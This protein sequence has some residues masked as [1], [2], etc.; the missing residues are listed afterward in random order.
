[1]AQV[2]A[3][4]G[5]A[6]AAAAPSRRKAR[7]RCAPLTVDGPRF[8]TG[9]R[10]R[11]RGAAPSPDL[12]VGPSSGRSVSARSQRS[13][14]EP[15]YR[16]PLDA[17]SGAGIGRVGASA[18]PTGLAPGCEQPSLEPSDVPQAESGN[19]C[20]LRTHRSKC[21]SPRASDRVATLLLD[22]SSIA[23]PRGARTAGAA[24]AAAV[25]A[26]WTGVGG[27]RR[28]ACGVFAAHERCRH[29]GHLRCGYVAEQR[30]HER[31]RQ[32][33]GDAGQTGASG[34]PADASCRSGAGR[35]RDHLGEPRLR[36]RRP[37]FL[38]IVNLHHLGVAG[39]VGAHRRATARADP[40]RGGCCLGVRAALRAGRRPVRERVWHRHLRPR[41]PRHP[42]GRS[43]AHA[44]LRP[45]RGDRVRHHLRRR[46]LY[47]HAVVG[48]HLCRQRQSRARR[49]AVAPGAALRRGGGGVGERDH[50]RRPRRVRPQPGDLPV[51]TVHRP[52]HADRHAAAGAD[53]CLG[54]HAR[55][56]HVRGRWHRAKRRGRRLGA[57]GG[58]GRQGAPSGHAAHA[59]VGRRRG[60][61]ARPDR[62]DRR[63]VRRR[64]DPHGAADQH[65][66]RASRQAARQAGRVQAVDVL[67]PA[68]RRP[69]DRRPRKQPDPARE[70]SPQ[71]AVALPEPARPAQAVLRRRHLLRA[72][73]PRDHL[74]PG[75]ESP[76]RHH[77][78]S[79]RQADLELRARGREGIDRPAT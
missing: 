28:A 42:P 70:P 4:P 61:P 63:H 72:G 38:R 73:R 53:A 45:G 75:G 39:I 31:L 79:P 65:G 43:A 66:Q 57:G 27:L 58:G 67:R 16:L 8:R 13:E 50:R 24:S 29:G 15:S 54:R 56:R 32:W 47:R 33:A 49:W 69:A 59:A 64:P 21:T 19:R 22:G 40:R 3:S 5:S 52:G 6:P 62:G 14:G 51:R 46:R 2:A 55:R 37:R 1:M 18:P 30:R 44:A 20:I 78:L 12:S 25:A 9:A 23:Q 76:D 17:P 11:V 68:A 41:Q 35:G 74:Q 36:L 48:S 77:Q 71:A 10:G 26:G 60:Q 7:R 34:H